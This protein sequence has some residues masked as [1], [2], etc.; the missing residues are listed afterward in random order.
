MGWVE[1]VSGNNPLGECPHFT[2][3]DLKP[4]LQNIQKASMQEKANLVHKSCSQV[5]LDL[6]REEK[7]KGFA[8]RNDKLIFLIIDFY[9]QPEIDKFNFYDSAPTLMCGTF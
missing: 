7:R 6:D 3:N 1:S 2:S 5:D 4:L 8:G 9:Q